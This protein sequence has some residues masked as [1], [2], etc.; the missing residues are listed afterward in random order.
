MSLFSIGVID[1]IKHKEIEGSDTIMKIDMTNLY[2]FYTTIPVKA[3][4]FLAVAATTY[5]S[6]INILHHRSCMACMAIRV[7]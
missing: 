4:K 2:V 7:A 5:H 3:P 6:I 1:T